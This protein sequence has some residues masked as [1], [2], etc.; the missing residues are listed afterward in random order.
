MALRDISNVTQTLINLISRAFQVPANWPGDVPS[1]VA[2]PPI[3][4]ST[5]GIGIYL[6]HVS[7]NAHYKNLPAPGRDQPPV[8]F[9]SMGLNLYYQLSA[10]STSAE[11]EADNAL[12]EQQMMAVALKAFHDYPELSDSTIVEGSGIA[13]PVFPAELLGR[14]NRFKISLQPIPP[15]EAVSFWT[16]GESPLTLSA[17]YEVSVI[18]LEPEVIQARAG[19]VLEYNIFSFV[20]GAPRILSSYNTLSFNSPVDGSPREIQ[21]Q[22]AQVPVG[23]EVQF[24]G[25][26]FAGG[27][28]RLL[29][30]NNRWT[31]PAFATAPWNVA[32]SSQS[33]SA[34]VQ[35]TAA[36]EDGSVAD[37]LPGI[38]GARVEVSRTH[39][40]SGQTVRQASNQCPFTITPAITAIAAPG[41]I[42][43]TWTVTGYIFQAT[44]L[45]GEELIELDVFVG[46]HRL[47]LLQGGGALSNGEY[48]LTNPQTLTF[49]LPT[50]LSSGQILPIRIFANGAETPPQWITVP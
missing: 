32:V 49:I 36:F 43:G 13:T 9:T 28:V 3:R 16:S 44:D 39:A 30:L 23:R 40:S 22:P 12:L 11:P 42:N 7:E 48:Q 33:I 24:D 38:Y 25:V 4:T 19:K 8:R 29:L 47:P 31:E 14:S 6:Y 46:Q 50:N 26:D 35:Q 37:I 15:S 20:S 5:H 34:T 10:N 21:L 2:S 27:T 45:D 41:N 1:V 17:Y 18:L